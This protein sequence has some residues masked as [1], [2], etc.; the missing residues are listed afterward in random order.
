MATTAP[1]AAGSSADGPNL[2]DSAKYHQDTDRACSASRA[3]CS[4]RLRRSPFSLM[5]PQDTPWAHTISR[6]SVSAV[7]N[8]VSSTTLSIPSSPEANA[9]EIKGSLSKRGQP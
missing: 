7:A 3:S 8:R 1:W 9:S 5:H 6:S 4:D 2:D